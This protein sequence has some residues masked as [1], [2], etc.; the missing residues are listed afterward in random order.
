MDFDIVYEIILL[1]AGLGLVVYGIKVINEGM[2][3][4]FGKKFQRVL[5]KNSKN[6]FKGILMGAGATTLLQSSTITNVMANG[7]LSV[8]TIGLKQS[9]AIGLGTA[10]GGAVAMFPLML[11]S[12]NISFLKIFSLFILVGAFMFVLCKKKKPRNIA[13][14]LLG[15]GMLCLGVT[16]MSDN[17]K[18]LVSLADLS[19]FFKCISNPV[20]MILIG[21]V[22]CVVTQTAY[23]VVAILIP[24]VGGFVSFEMACYAVLGVNLGAGLTISLLVATLENSENGNGKRFL[25]FNVFAK[26]FACV[27]IGLLLLIPNWA[28]FLHTQAFG[29]NASISLVL[30]NL[31]NNMVP[32]LL[33]PF[34]P[35][36]EKLFEKMFRNSKSKKSDYASFEIEDSLLTNS[37]IVLEKIKQNYQRVFALNQ[38]FTQES[39]D[40]LF[41]KQSKKDVKTNSKLIDRACKLCSNNA[42]RYG[43][44]F[45]DETAEKLKIYVDLFANQKQILKSNLEALGLSKDYISEKNAISKKQ[46]KFLQT[47]GTDILDMQKIVFDV[48]VTKN[49]EK[50]QQDLQVVFQMHDQNEKNMMK[51]KKECLASKQQTQDS[52]L[53]F[54]IICELDKIENEICDSAIKILLLED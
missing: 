14:F 23:S 2:L 30:F 41:G 25:L 35:C 10:I 20:L 12:T 7:F 18:D 29:G 34:L 24:L 48:S 33:W 52:T 3:N 42:I 50:A 27:L 43:G 19:G 28:N 37:A 26:L 9:M 44:V 54:A 53:F 32:L 21:M 49:K 47:L 31:F 45:E 13:L 38:N 4:L 22:L 5:A 39:F 1:L 11:E 40:V 15:F 16:M 46:Q 8:G 36:F 6:S 51:A 17:I